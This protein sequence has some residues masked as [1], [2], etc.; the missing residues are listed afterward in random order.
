VRFAER[1]QV[2]ERGL[3]VERRHIKHHLSR[4]LVGAL[5]GAGHHVAG[6]QLGVRVH[7]RHKALALRVAKHDQKR[8]AVRNADRRVKLH[9]LHVGG[10]RPGARRHGDPVARSAGGVCG[11]AVERP[12][13]ARGQHRGAGVHRGNGAVGG[14]ARTPHPP[15]LCEEPHGRRPV[16]N[17]DLRVLGEVGQ[18]RLV[19]V[20]PRGRVHV[21]DAIRRVRRLSAVIVRRPVAPRVE[22]HV[23]GVDEHVSNGRVGVLGKHLHRG[24]VA[25]VAGG[26]L[27]VALERLRVLPRHR[28]AALRPPGG[29]PFGPRGFG[30][31]DHRGA[32]TGRAEGRGE[33]GNAGAENE[34]V[35]GRQGHAC[36]TGR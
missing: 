12:N 1:L 33:A 28:N 16:G 6:R 20:L 14:Q 19:D 17:L 15:L 11:V 26:R 4:A 13:A 23:Q 10:V 3:K 36:R 35:W 21:Q 30:G 25:G 9:E 18:E 24:W 31:D 22:V 5:H 2:G 29:R 27:D 7:R 32:L 34:N 8:I